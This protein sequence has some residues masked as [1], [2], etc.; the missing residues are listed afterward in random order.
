MN[1]KALKKLVAAG[2]GSIAVGVIV[3]ISGIV[4]GILTIVNGALVLGSRKDLEI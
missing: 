4:C 2:A 1:H 3:L